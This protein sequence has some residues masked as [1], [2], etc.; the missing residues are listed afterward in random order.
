MPLWPYGVRYGREPL[1]KCA[2]H[3]VMGKSLWR[4]FS[5]IAIS[6]VSISP[7]LYFAGE[8]SSPSFFA[9]K[10]TVRSALKAQRSALPFEASHP[11][12]ISHA[13][14]R[15]EVSFAALN[16][17]A[18]SLRRVPLKPVPKT[19]SIMTSQPSSAACRSVITA[20]LLSSFSKAA[21]ASSVH[22]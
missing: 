15:A 6:A 13:M 20:T 9:W 11:E 14:R 1:T 2:S 12:G 10:V 8:R 4:A 7:Q 19:Q 18:C 21:A 22:G 16:I 3:T 17:F 5:G